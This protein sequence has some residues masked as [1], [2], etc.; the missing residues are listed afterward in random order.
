M[1]LASGADQ[2]SFLLLI[3]CRCYRGWK[4]R[5]ARNGR[6]SRNVQ[7][8]PPHMRGRRTSPPNKRRELALTGGGELGGG[9][10][11]AGDGP[12]AVH[13]GGSRGAADTFATRRL[14]QRRRP[15][16]LEAEVA[17]SRLALP[18]AHHRYLLTDQWGPRTGRASGEF[19]H[20]RPVRRM[21]PASCPEVRRLEF[22][23]QSTT[24]PAGATT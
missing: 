21:R 16:P 15:G 7:R 22:A 1:K 2:R 11:L 24:V 14:S 13:V 3:L 20:W 10:R 8:N 19:L 17:D 6:I 9:S 4:I 5:I 18:L 12:G 23:R